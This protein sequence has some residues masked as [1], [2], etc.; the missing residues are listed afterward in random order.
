M[1]AILRFSRTQLTRKLD[2]LPLPLRLIFAA[3]CAERLLPAYVTSSNLTGKGDPE[4]LARILARLWEDIA[5]DP[6]TE[7]EV[8]ANISTC[9][10][11]IPTDY[12]EPWF[13]E[14]AS[15]E[16]ASTAVVYALTCRQSGGSQEAMWSAEQ[17]YNALDHFVINRE[18]VD[19]NAPE[20]ESRLL[21]H[22]LLQAELARQRRD[23]E[24]LFGAVGDDVRQ[25]AAKF[26]QRAKAEAKIV[27][28]TS[29]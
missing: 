15:A 3:T 22:P 11:L 18:N 6:M 10:D 19:L 1:K 7:S 8:Q 9:M 26:R 5:G 20:A 4:T 17:A 24:E 2:R 21:A 29:S 13:V 16:N 14:Q 12:H 25:T 27:F 23:I 28:D